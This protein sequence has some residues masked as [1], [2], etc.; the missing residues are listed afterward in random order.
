[1][2]KVQHYC[3]GEGSVRVD[4]FQKR[5]PEKQEQAIFT[6]TALGGKEGMKLDLSGN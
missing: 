1:M 4:R 2:T 6:E 3:V 5:N